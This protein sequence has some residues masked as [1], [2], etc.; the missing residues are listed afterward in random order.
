MVRRALGKRSR[1]SPLP[2]HRLRA[3][4]TT[5]KAPPHQIATLGTCQP[6]PVTRY[7]DRL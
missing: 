2:E 1:N 7:G 3:R 5:I 6:A 4:A